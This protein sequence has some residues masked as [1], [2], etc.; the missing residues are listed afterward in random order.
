MAELLAEQG[1]DDQAQDV[2]EAAVQAEEKKDENG[3]EQD[4]SDARTVSATLTS[5]P[6]SR[7]I[8]LEQFTLLFHGYELLMDAK[9]ELNH[10]RCASPARFVLRTNLSAFSALAPCLLRRSNFDASFCCMVHLRARR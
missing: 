7:D 6:L 1:L 5:H 10:G 9:M 3:E 2:K 4:E 8:H